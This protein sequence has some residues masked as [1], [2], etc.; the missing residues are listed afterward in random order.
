MDMEYRYLRSFVYWVFG[1]IYLSAL[2]NMVVE[3]E[4]LLS[5]SFYALAAMKEDLINKSY[6]ISIKLTLLKLKHY[7]I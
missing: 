2:Y 7:I 6:K 1:I 4:P 3:K 5:I